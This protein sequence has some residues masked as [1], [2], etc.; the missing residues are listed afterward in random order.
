MKCTNPPL[1]SLLRLTAHTT[2]PGFTL[3]C[4]T[5]TITWAAVYLSAALALVRSTGARFA[6]PNIN[7]AARATAGTAVRK[8][9]LLPVVGAGAGAVVL[10]LV[11]KPALLRAGRATGAALLVALLLGSCGDG[12]SN[13]SDAGTASDTSNTS[14]TNN[15]N[16][17]NN[18]GTA[19]DSTA[20]TD[21]ST[22]D[23]AASEAAPELP[24]TQGVTADEIVLGSHTDLSGPVAIWGVGTINGMRMRFDEANAAGGV[25]G[26][27]IRLVVEDTQYQ[28]PKAIQ[29]AN[30]LINRD[31]I[32]AMVMALGTPTNNAV[33]G[34]QLAQGV[35]NMYPMTGARSMS[36]PFHPLKF[37]QRG[38]Y[39]D[40]IRAG[41]RYFLEQENKTT[42]CVIHQDSDYGQEVMDAATDQLA[43]M[44]REVVAVAKHVPTEIEFTATIIRLRNA[45][46]DVVFMG[47]I[48]TDTIRILETAKT[49]DFAAVF[50]GNNAAYGQVIA[51]QQTGS[52]EGY[53]A[54]THVA[55]P[56][57]DDADLSA[58]AA[59]WWD[60]YVER[61]GEEPD[62]PALEG[63][64]GAD[65]VVEALTRAGPD[66]TREAFLQATESITDYVDLF[67]YRVQF[68]P[69]DHQ[70][71][72]ES[73][74]SVIRAGRWHKVAEAITY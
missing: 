19:N 31:Q 73:T 61:F 62:L 51:D 34:T 44:G 66:L 59:A 8:C 48:H 2:E 20:T 23:T 13:G 30:K 46:C 53:H 16:N 18:N 41:V 70:G 52:G 11:P 58:E 38:T 74:L 1:R 60:R 6:R 35:P 40:E 28:I 14:N 39:Y 21:N 27:Q 36:E 47:T 4:V 50:V 65:L 67:G 43:A 55:K 15:T 29:A 10:K 5:H 72:G 56:Y 37:T 45:G 9:T 26:R 7:H 63:Y 49:M 64:R 24:P 25:H 17:T 71:V 3:A 68:G 42:P 12:G 57:R 54:F 32:F 33:L 69:N 22:S